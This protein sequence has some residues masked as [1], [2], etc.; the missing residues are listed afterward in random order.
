MDKCLND[1]SRIRICRSNGRKY[2][3]NKRNIVLYVLLIFC[4]LILFAYFNG[5]LTNNE[6]TNWYIFSAGK[7]IELLE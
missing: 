1:Y 4:S 5:F 6:N 3:D 7:I 2:L